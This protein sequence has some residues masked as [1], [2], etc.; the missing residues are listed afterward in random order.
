MRNE[1]SSSCASTFPPPGKINLGEV[2]E[3]RGGGAGRRLWRSD[4][5]W[6][7][8]WSCRG[9]QATA[10][11]W[12]SPLKAGSAVC[13][14][15]EAR[16]SE[17]FS[18]LGTA[19][20][21]TSAPSTAERFWQAPWCSFLFGYATQGYRC[22]SQNWSVPLFYLCT[23]VPVS[24]F[25]VKNYFCKKSKCK[26]FVFPHV[27]PLLVWDHSSPQTWAKNMHLE[28]FF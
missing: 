19:V 6:L 11:A 1:S 15:S 25:R 5:Q 13:P 9:E 17:M 26:T 20:W 27:D 21:Q 16:N 24:F 2:A 7:R 4:G 3:P 23:W 14:G 28:M 8:V 10:V 18:F 12:L 22:I